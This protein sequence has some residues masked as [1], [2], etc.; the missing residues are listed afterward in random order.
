MVEPADTDTSVGVV[1][2]LPCM[3]SGVYNKHGWTKP[4]DMAALDT[5]YNKRVDG[6]VLALATANIAVID[7][8]ASFLDAVAS[9]EALRETIKND[10]A[11]PTELREISKNKERW[12]ALL[13]KSAK[14]QGKEI[15]TA[16]SYK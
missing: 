9:C 1:P 7:A 11:A 12:F 16:R 14:A 4:N 2:Q 5:N 6:V 8:N 13:D 10:S 15:C 3:S